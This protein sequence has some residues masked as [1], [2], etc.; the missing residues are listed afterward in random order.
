[1]AKIVAIHSFRGGT[2]KSN[3]TANIAALLA[4]AG[5]RVGIIDTDIQSPGIHVLF[6]LRGGTIGHSLNDYLWGRCSIQQT[7]HPVLKGLV[8]G[9]VFLVPSSIKADS[10]V[11]VL[12]QGY[13]MQLLTAAFRDLID[14]L[15]L[16][17]LLIDTHPGLNEETLFALAIANVLAIVLRPDQQDYEGTGVALGVAR[18]LDV[19]RMRLV[20][21]KAPADSDLASIKAH[22]E[23]TFDCSVAAVLPHSDEM[24]KLASSD[25][26]A[27]RYPSHSLTAALREVAMQLVES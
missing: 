17:T 22:V 25:I 8:G 18:A 3:T 6:G 11:Q 2:G 15:K 27:L 19:P 7:A 24:M 5:Q 20:V 12:R 9:Q 26:F 1:M 23:Q 13:D 4:A 21:N 10:I 16:D 14:T